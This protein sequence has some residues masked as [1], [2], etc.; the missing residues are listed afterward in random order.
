MSRDDIALPIASF[1]QKVDAASKEAGPADRKE[2]ARLVVLLFTA[3]RTCHEAFLRDRNEP[4][5]EN[6]E[7][8]ETSIV[9]LASAR[10]IPGHY[11][12][13]SR[14]RCLG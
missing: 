8:W 13:Y 5:D 3:V 10:K 2:I 4:S 11:L 1:I 7:A 14:P 9:T 6:I 12:A